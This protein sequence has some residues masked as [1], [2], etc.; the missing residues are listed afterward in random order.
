MCRAEDNNFLPAHCPL[1]VDAAQDAV[2]LSGLQAHT[3]ASGPAFIHQDTLVLTSGLRS[4]SSP[5]LHTYPALP[6]QYLALGF[7][8]PHSVCM[9]SLFKP[10]QVL[11][12]GSKTLWCII[13]P[14]KFWSLI[15]EIPSCSLGG[16]MKLPHLPRAGCRRPRS[17]WHGCN[18]RN[19]A[20]WIA[21]TAAAQAEARGEQ[22]T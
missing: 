21:P 2:G 18:E 14:S 10:V 4:W 20:C 15:S 5:S 6:Q 22:S 13:H 12:N 3:A 1:C 19:G 16:R 17:R 8:E 11:L 9:G 7:D